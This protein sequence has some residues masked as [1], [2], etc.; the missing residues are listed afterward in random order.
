[1]FRYY[2]GNYITLDFCSLQAK[3]ALN[4]SE[5]LK[6]GKSEEKLDSLKRLSN[7]SS[8]STF[9]MEFINK[10]GHQQIIKFVTDGRQYV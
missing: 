4:I 9:A 5:K 2:T 8:D 1:V 10:N 7:L 6:D 3:T